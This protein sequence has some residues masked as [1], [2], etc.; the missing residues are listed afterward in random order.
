MKLFCPFSGIRYSLDTFKLSSFKEQKIPHPFLSFPLNTVLGT[1]LPAFA[2]ETIFG[3]DLHLFGT[4]LLLKLPIERW[5]FPLLEKAPLDYWIPFWLSNVEKLAGIVK[6]LDGKRPKDLISFS[7]HTEEGLAPL[8]N[9][10]DW[11]AEAHIALNAFHA[12]ISEEARKRNKDF[13]ANLNE[14]EFSTEEQCNFIIEKILRGSISSSREKQKFPELIANWAARVGN[15]PNSTFRT[16]NGERKTIRNFWKEIIQNAFDLGAT[17]KGYSNILT[18]D[19]TV[20]DLDELQEHC[21]ESIPSGTLHSR[22]LWEELGKLK[23]VILEF[24]SPTKSSDLSIEVL[25]SSDI[26][27]IMGEVSHVSPVP[28]LLNDDPDMPR[29]EDYPSLSSFVKAKMAYKNQK[30]KEA[31][32]EAKG[33]KK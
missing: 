33:E 23:E 19:I 12:P 1:S 10:S 13:R 15:F 25:T 17:G 20:D 4:Y 21:M 7:V 2:N 5:N 26:E 18:S 32:D 9:L 28:S 24:K 3:E 31:K 29:K 30:E 27:S 16:S 22:A 8:S 6:R 14:T 11:I